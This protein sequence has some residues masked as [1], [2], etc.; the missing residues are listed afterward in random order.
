MSDRSF[1]GQWDGL[2]VTYLKARWFGR[3]RSSI[4]FIV[5]PDLWRFR[6]C[7]RQADVVHI[8]GYRHFLYVG[9][10][11][12]T[13]LYR[14]PF[15]FQAHGTMT[16]EF[17]RQ[18]LKKAFDRT[19]GRLTARRVSRA[20]ALTKAEIGD[21]ERLGIP[22]SAVVKIPNLIRPDLPVPW[23]DR[24]VFRARYG[25]G[26]QEK[27]IL[28]LSRLQARKGLD[29]LITAVA[30]LGDPGVRLVVVGPD[31]GFRARAEQLS[32]ELGMVGSVIFTGPLYG[33]EKF[34]AYSAADLY[35][36]TSV[37]GEGLPVAV[38]EA[39]YAGTPVLLTDSIEISQLVDGR[40][41]LATAV[42]VNAIQEAL[43]TMLNDPER[44]Q[45]FSQQTESFIKKYFDPETI[46]DRIEEC[47][48]S[49]V[50]DS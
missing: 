44:L 37:G 32:D 7:F 17:G 6:H 46:L 29:L 26:A 16:T 38:V 12:F 14:K 22:D 50:G 20:I 11:I 40:V 42:D 43:A 9:A 36:L 35:A 15:I 25:I 21:Y 34:E 13:Q 31:H 28:F 3:S 27:M 5:A 41:G 45:Y 47:Y 10:S 1:I 4:G 24:S 33:Q 48:R 8:H 18:A 2:P 19:M 30:N 23:P 39:C 49:A